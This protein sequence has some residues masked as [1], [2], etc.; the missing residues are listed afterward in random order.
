MPSDS[1]H[2]DQANHNIEFL[3]YFYPQFKFNDWAVTVSFYAA[4]HIIEFLI[5]KVKTITI[6]GKSISI[7]HSN[8]FFNALNKSGIPLTSNST[9]TSDHIARKIIVNENFGPIA[10]IYLSL[11]NNSRVARYYCQSWPKARLEMILKPHLNNF[12]DWL[13]ANHG[14]HFSLPVI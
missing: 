8:Q 6:K 3:R 9:S 12:F 11:Y 10:N 7:E 13:N 5:F 2:I 14:T 1:V 4:V